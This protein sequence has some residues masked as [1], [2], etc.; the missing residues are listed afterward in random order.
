MT[1]KLSQPKGLPDLDAIITNALRPALLLLP[2]KM[3]TIEA[4]TLLLAIGLQESRL[5]FRR[6]HG[7]GPARGLLQFERGGGVRGV[8]RHKATKDLAAS[9]C[10]ARGVSTDETDVWAHLEVDDVLAFAFGRLLLYSDPAPLPSIGE[11]KKAWDYYIR[12]WRPGKP[13]GDTWIDNFAT[14]VEAAK[15]RY[16]L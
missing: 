5:K 7:N 10:K 15:K 11:P 4:E 3:S 2:L 8:L 12:T 6:Q 9:V 16:W 14:A 1:E 13:H